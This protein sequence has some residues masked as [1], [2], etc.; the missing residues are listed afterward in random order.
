MLEGLDV[1]ALKKIRFTK[2]STRFKK[3]EYFLEKIKK[4]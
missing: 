2:S 3:L 1:V 4:S